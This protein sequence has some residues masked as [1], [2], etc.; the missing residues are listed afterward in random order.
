MLRT[1]GGG[2][3]PSAGAPLQV[4]IIGAGRISDL[5]ARGYLDD[6]RARVTV[7]CDRDIEL[8]RAKAAA[9]GVPDAVVVSDL[10]EALVRPDVDLVE[11]LLP[12][13]LHHDVARAALEAGKDVSLQ[14]PIGLSLAEADAVIETAERT[15]RTLRIFE[16]FLSYPP[17]QRAKSLVEAGEIGDPLTIRVKS[18]G[19]ISPGAWTVPD[20]ALAWRQD[21][22]RCGGGPMMFDDGAHKFALL[23]HFMGVPQDVHAW[24]GRTEVAPGRYKDAPSIVSL[25][26]ADGRVGSFEAA[27]ARD[28]ELETSQYAQDDRIE[29]TG[30]KGVVWVTRGHGRMTDEAPVILYRDRRTIAF[31]DLD[32]RWDRS[33][34]YATRELIDALIRGT[35]PSVRPRDARDILRVALAAQES[36]R[37]GRA[38][39]V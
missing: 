27:Y 3:R 28:L 29:I 18:T 33:F 36:A 39:A 17:V 20:Q 19:G 11:I 15:G 13:H 4:A 2:R 7:V 8:A 12:H 21:P 16:N 14:K 24:I 25:R 22:T 35:A 37:A 6:D 38:V 10:E 32:A 23:V 31:S 26:W 5:H 34:V 9:W 30:T 1:G